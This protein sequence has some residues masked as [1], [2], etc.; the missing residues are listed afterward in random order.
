MTAEEL[1]RDILK[2]TLD[3]FPIEIFPKEI[4]E[5]INAAHYG[6][7]LPKDYLAASM[8]FA[9]SVSIGNSYHLVAMEGWK[10]VCVLWL[11]LIGHSGINKSHPLSLALEPIFEKQQKAFDEYQQEIEEYESWLMKSRSERKSEGE[12]YKRKPQLKKLLVSDYTPESLIEVHQ[13]NLRGLG[14]YSD[15]LAGWINNFNRYNK[16]NEEQFWLSAWSC[17]PIV[18][19]RRTAGS[20]MVKKP[21]IGVVGTIQT[22][23]LKDL[24]RGSKGKNGFF[25]RMLF[26]FPEN[27]KKMPWSNGGMEINHKEKYVKT[28]KDIL[29]QCSTEGN[30]FKE[31]ELTF[32]ND[33]KE[34]VWEWQT[35]NTKKSNDADC[36][37]KRAFYAKLEVY[38]LRFCIILQVLHDT[39]QIEKP[40]TIKLNSANSAIKLAEYFEGNALRVLEYLQNVSPTDNL[41]KD[42]KD[43]CSLLPDTFGYKLAKELGVKCKLSE[44]TVKR[45]LNN[46]R[47][48]FRL[49]Q[50]EY[51][52]KF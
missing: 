42:K 52:K 18:V 1:K 26:V 2:N 32:E 28:I 43:F 13:N 23:L 25:E 29:E 38:V 27:L 19:D 34:K 50:G 46:D 20:F 48:F 4:Q 16:G 22:A 7:N 11:V 47:L 8:L 31:R 45:L 3:P 12:Q 36:D 17:K 40:T 24:A 6:L 21:F 44:S 49:R 37:Q 39:I 35:A 9:V 51:E 10:E 5:I 15:E 33:A 41:T 30:E 14:V